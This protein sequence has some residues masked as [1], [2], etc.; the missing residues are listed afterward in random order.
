[1]NRILRNRFSVD[2]EIRKTQ[3]VTEFIL[4]LSLDKSLKNTA[5]FRSLKMFT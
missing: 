3:K 1:M 5:H 2:V 4:L